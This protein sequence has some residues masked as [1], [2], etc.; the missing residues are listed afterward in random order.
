[1]AAAFLAQGPNSKWIAPKTD[2]SVR[3]NFGTYV[4][5]I[6]FSL[7][8]F[9]PAT[10]TISGQWSIDNDGTDILI[11]GVST[12]QTTPIDAY[13]SFS[14][15]SITSG[16][17]AGVNTIDFVLFNDPDSGR[18]TN[19]TGLRVEISGTAD[20]LPTPTPTP[21]GGVPLDIPALDPRAIALLTALLVWL[22]VGALRR[23]A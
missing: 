19:P 18:Y 9:N 1:V 10:A 6:T 14:P 12:G 17:V 15:F 5:R 7:A 2:Q 11:N 8:G 22:R 4:Y 23:G 21:T 3:E 20:P 16:F 13:D